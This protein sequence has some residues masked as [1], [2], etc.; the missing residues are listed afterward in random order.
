MSATSADR[1]AVY[2][3]LEPVFGEQAALRLM[4]H[5]NF[6]PERE[7]VSSSDMQ[8]NT[9]MLQGEMAEL[10]GELQGEMAELR[11]ELRGEMAELRGEL[12]GEMAELRSDLR[13]EM[14]ELRA[15][16]HGEMTELR[17]ELRG[18]M[19]ALRA[20]VNTQIAGLQ[21]WAAGILAVNGVALAAALLT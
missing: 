15:E 12:R 13:G 3:S 14:A 17:A 2:E 21:R 20:D 19:A 9:M 4:D 10:R 1:Q 5:L 11:A 7:L 6:T 18:E 8:A 16:L